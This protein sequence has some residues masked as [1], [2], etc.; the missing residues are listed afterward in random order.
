[1]RKVSCSRGR[2]TRAKASQRLVLTWQCLSC[3]KHV[4]TS[5]IGVLG[6][7]CECGLKP[8]EDC[9]AKGEN[10]LDTSYLN[11]S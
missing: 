6:K 2:H 10:M 8:S 1:M 9:N 11:S 3:V 4:E 7:G 5:C